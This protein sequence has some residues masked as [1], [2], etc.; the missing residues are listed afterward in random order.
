M[1]AFFNVPVAAFYSEVSASNEK[2]T[3]RAKISA[4]VADTNIKR[5]VKAFQALND[6]KLKAAIL[7]VAEEMARRQSA[8]AAQRK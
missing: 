2:L 4:G 8:K 5:L 3:R 1:A 6:K 7:S